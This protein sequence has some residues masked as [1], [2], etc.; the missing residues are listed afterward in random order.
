MRRPAILAVDAGG[1]KTDAVLIRR[2][3]TVLGAARI[4]GAEHDGPGGDAHLEVVAA[5]VEAAGRNA[6][7]NGAGAPIAELGVYCQAGADLTDD[8]RRITKWLAG[9][10][11]SSEDV[12]RNDTFAVLRAGTERGWGVAVVCGYGTNCSGVSPGGREFRLSALGE[13]SGDWG[14]GGDLGKAALWL[15]VRAEDGRGVATALRGLVPAHFGMRRPSQLV[16][17]LHDGRIAETRLEELAPAVFR[18]AA[19]GDGA[20]R[21]IVDRQ[22][23]EV[24]AMA[25]AAIRRLRLGST[26]AEVV[27]GGSVFRAKDPAFFRRMQEGLAAVAPAARMLV[28]DAPPVLGAAL[29]G[30]DRVA[31]PASARRRLRASLTERR[32]AAGTRRSRKG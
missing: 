28:L 16:R 24:V 2:D 21:S 29:L 17:A 18:A 31:A 3:G 26:D 14:G 9:R 1:S 13:I 12:V 6:G 10:G 32:L 20:A 15:A 25:G 5:A 4:H 7:W 11:L 8:V 22:A 30:L 27:L 19:G 23:D